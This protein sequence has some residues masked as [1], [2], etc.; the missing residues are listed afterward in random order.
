MANQ[1][2]EIEKQMH[3]FSLGF[4]NYFGIK[5][6]STNTTQHDHTD[7]PAE[8]WHQ[9]PTFHITGNGWINDPCG[10]GYDPK[11]KLYHLFYQCKLL[12]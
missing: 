4:L 2:R 1:L 6:A 7:R 5:S 10:P 9:R 11:T 3:D 12:L 8:G